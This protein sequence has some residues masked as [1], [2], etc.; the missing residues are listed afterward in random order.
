MRC[1]WFVIPVL[2][3]L[4]T[5]AFS[6]GSA[7]AQTTAVGPYYATPSWDQKLTSSTRF[8][9]LS[10]WDSEAVLDRETGLVWE[11]SAGDKNGNGDVEDERRSW[12][13]AGAYC[14]N[15]AVGGRK[16][17]R[18]PTVQELS[19]LVDPTQ[20]NPSLPPGHPF[21]NVVRPAFGAAIFAWTSTTS[22][23]DPSRAWG[24]F[25]ATSASFTDGKG[26]ENFVWCVRGGQ[27]LDAQ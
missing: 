8:I 24:V 26:D 22:A 9:V 13:A 20:A 2:G 16:G 23:P 6:G 19:S 25:F 1:Q 21:T 11:R 27:G 14:A 17:W 3:F 10:N 18:L 4:G 15:A 12:A 5:L 7:H